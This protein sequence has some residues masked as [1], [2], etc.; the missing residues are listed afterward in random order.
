MPRNGSGTYTWPAGSFNPA[1][2]GVQATPGDWNT[3]RADLETA[4]SNSIAANGETVVTNDLPMAT[5]KHTGVGNATARAHYTS[6][7]QRQDGGGIYAAAAGTADVITLALVPVIT[8]YVIGQRFSF[9][10][11]GA[12]TTN[13]TLN[14]NG[15]GAGA[16]VWPNG[17]ALVAGDIPSGAMICVEVSATTPVFHLQTVPSARGA[18]GI[19]KVQTFS[20]NGTYTPSAGMVNC[21]IEAVGG[22]GGGGGSA[23]ST[24]SNYNGAAGGGAGSYSRLLATAADIGASK[25]V[26]IG[27]LGA[28]GVAG[29]NPGGNGADT[30][31]GTLC[32]AKGGTGGPGN[33]NTIATNNG[34]AGGVAGTG[35]VTIPGQPGGSGG[36]GQILAPSGFGGS[37]RFG[38]GGRGTTTITTAAG[39]AGAGFGAGGA[40]AVSYDNNGTAAGGAGTVGYVVITEFCDR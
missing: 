12:N 20:V 13:V 34:G 6:M 17:T 9:K 2:S 19:V 39:A 4:V 27:A 16:V 36:Q 8:A 30:S 28:G 35:T 11:S 32:I 31:V 15:V 37:G 14:V 21:I 3:D 25:T 38:S 22:G 23:G 29:N 24:A 10:S 18:A 1:T 5:F 7:G 33:S 26:T 40:G